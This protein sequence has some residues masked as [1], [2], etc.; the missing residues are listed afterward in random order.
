MSEAQYISSSAQT[1][2]HQLTVWA[3]G[4]LPQNPSKREKLQCEKSRIVRTDLFCSFFNSEIQVELNIII[5]V[6]TAR[7]QLVALSSVITLQIYFAPTEYHKT[8]RTG[9]Y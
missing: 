4:L 1:K 7:M 9:V 3:Q 5:S 6:T 2:T 8:Q